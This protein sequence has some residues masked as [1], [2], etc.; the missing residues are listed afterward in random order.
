MRKGMKGSFY[1]IIELVTNFK[2]GIVS[3]GGA[4]IALRVVDVARESLGNGS[5][6]RTQFLFSAFGNQLNSTIGQVL[7]VTFHV[8]SG[9][10]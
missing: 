6:K 4:R 1:E 3:R 9:G 8:E 5:L 2:R 10:N 7:H